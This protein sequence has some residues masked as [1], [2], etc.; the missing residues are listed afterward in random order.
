MSRG[1][2]QKEKW[3]LGEEGLDGPGGRAVMGPSL[4]CDLGGRGFATYLAYVG[5]MS[6][7]RGGL[8]DQAH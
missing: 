6:T 5:P 8:E 1:L 3:L 7:G 4:R 2:R